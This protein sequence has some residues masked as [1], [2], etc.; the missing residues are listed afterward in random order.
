M[1]LHALVLA[2]ENPAVLW[3]APLLTGDFHMIR[4]IFGDTSGL[5]QRLREILAIACPTC[6]RE[7]TVEL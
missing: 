3:N 1:M 7:T 2:F 5:I 6:G 4:T